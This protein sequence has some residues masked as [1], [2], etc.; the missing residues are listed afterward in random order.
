[1]LHAC[2]VMFFTSCNFKKML[3][4]DYLK[5]LNRCPFCNVNDRIIL[6][7]TYAYL[8]Y[9]LAPYHT[10]HL[11]VMPKRHVESIK[12]LKEMELQEILFLER[13]G[14]EILETLDYESITLLVREGIVG[15][16]KSVRHTHFHVIPKIRIGNLDHYQQEREA[17]GA[18]EIQKTMDEISIVL[19][20]IQK[21]K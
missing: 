11:L 16:A 20:N 10:H 18:E 12:E 2:R 21:N 9:A 8:T 15:E 14:L 3:Y 5:Q 17:L 4:K 6:E 19:N 13:I 1:M 7:K